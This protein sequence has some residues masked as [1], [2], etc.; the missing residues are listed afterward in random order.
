MSAHRLTKLRLIWFTLV[1]LIVVVSFDNATTKL[2]L[3]WLKLVSLIVVVSFD[4]ATTKL[5]PFI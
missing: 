2:R 4:N 5:M 1:S 3:I